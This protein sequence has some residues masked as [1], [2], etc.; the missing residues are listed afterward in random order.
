VYDGF[1]NNQTPEFT[2]VIGGDFRQPFAGNL[3]FRAAVEA[4]SD[5][6]GPD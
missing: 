6:P 1:R 4:L 5:K 2:A 3:E